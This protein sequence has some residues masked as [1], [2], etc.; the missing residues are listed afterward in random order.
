MKPYNSDGY[1]GKI[2][3]F[4]F[5]ICI[6]ICKFLSAKRIYSKII[7]T[8]F[9][10]SGNKDIIFPNKLLITS[11]INLKFIQ[12]ETKF[13]VVIKRKLNKDNSYN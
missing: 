6:W 11:G 10:A 7:V 13:E 12:T 9:N 5:Y 2:I 8:I 1:E 3:Q 4:E